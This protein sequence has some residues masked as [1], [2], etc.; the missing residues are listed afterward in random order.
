[1][2]AIRPATINLAMVVGHFGMDQCFSVS[3]G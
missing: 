3:G 1:M 2:G